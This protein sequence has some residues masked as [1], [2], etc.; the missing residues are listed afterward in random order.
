MMQRKESSGRVVA[1]RQ[2][3]HQSYTLEASF[4]GADSE[5]GAEEEEEEK[6]EK[7]VGSTSLSTRIR[8]LHTIYTNLNPSTL[9]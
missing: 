9:I 8:S 6:E 1:W 5:V 2:F 3:A 4:G 7:L